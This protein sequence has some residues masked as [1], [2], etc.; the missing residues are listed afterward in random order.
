MSSLILINFISCA[1]HKNP[2]A[3][4]NDTMD[5]LK[6]ESLSRYDLK[7]LQPALKKDN[8]LALCHNN[9]FD[10]AQKILKQKLDEKINDFNYWNKISTC[11]ILEKEYSKARYFL[12]IALSR[13]KKNKDKSIILNN[14]GLVLLE[15]KHFEE[16]KDYFKKSIE[17]SSKYL[18]PKF[19]LVQI[20]LKFG[21]YKKADKEINLLLNANNNDIDFLNAKA[22]T[23]LMLK[24]YK[25]ALVYF[26]KIPKDYRKRDDIATN[27][28]M[29]Y[30]MLGLYNNAKEIITS[31]EK[32][33]QYFVEK[34]EQ[35]VKNIDI[36]HEKT[37]Q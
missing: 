20:Y 1:S 7:R 28:A 32:S 29:T 9:D 35:I 34:Q 18:T 10:K 37:V 13:A 4:S 30:Y 21:I 17:L 12:D 11:Y 27:M 31:A 3:I 14:I 15:Q 19:N 33:D 5:G 2:R 26:N 23:Q 8:P 36:L 25:N 24:E 6:Y 16:A 22:H